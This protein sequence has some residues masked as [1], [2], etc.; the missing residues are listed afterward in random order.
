MKGISNHPYF[1]IRLNSANKQGMTV[2]L[3]FLVDS[4]RK[5]YFPHR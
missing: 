4:N 2:W 5:A 1:Y 3:S